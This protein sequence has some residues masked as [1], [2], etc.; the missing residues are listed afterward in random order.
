ME[1]RKIKV[2]DASNY[3]DM[4][5]KLDKETK[6]MMFEPG[7][8][9]TDINSI[10]SIIGKSIKGE[11]LILVATY[12]EVIVG[13][14]SVDRGGFKRIKHTGYLVMGICQGYRN[15]GIGTKLFSELDKWVL[16]NNITRLE[17][18]VICSNTIAKRLY[19]KNGFEV[20]GIKKNSMI[21]D[22][23]YVD[24]FYMAKQEYKGETTKYDIKNISR[25]Y[26]KFTSL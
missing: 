7:E 5:I 2:E 18:T 11:N 8:R 12:D 15:M 20:E 19:E 26:N 13:F 16:E 14:L 1:I 25:K 22:G 17:L 9:S 23:Q 21:I 10:K 4:L 6:F 24:E 3:L